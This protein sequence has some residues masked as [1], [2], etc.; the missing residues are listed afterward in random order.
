MAQKGNKAKKA[1]AWSY[2][3]GKKGKNRVRAYEDARDGALMLEWYEPLFDNSG[4]VID[5]RTGRQKVRRERISLT[6]NGVTTRVEAVAKAEQFA[7]KVDELSA[8]KAKPEPAHAASG[9]G[10]PEVVTLGYLLD[11]YFEEVVPNKRA[12]TRKQNDTDQR[13]FLAYFGRDAVVERIGPK[14]RPV[15]EMGRVR[16]ND[17]VRAR[18][19]GTIP[20]FAKAKGQTIRN[21]VRF[22][23]AVFKWAKLERDDGT[24]L[25]IRNPWEGFPDPPCDTPVRQEMTPELHRKLAEN[26]KNWRMAV[27]MEICRE[28][29]RRRNSVRLLAMEDIDL[30]RGAVRWQGEFDKVGKTRVTPLTRKAVDAILRAL[31]HRRAEGMDHSPWL[32]PAEANP[33]QPVPLTRL[34]NWMR[35]TKK[36]QGL[37]LP[38]LGYHGEKRAGIRDPKFR[39]LDP[40]VQEE[41]AGTT[42]E[43]MRRVYDYVD[44]PTL[45]N[46]VALLENDGDQPTSGVPQIGTRRGLKK[47]A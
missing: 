12:G 18:Q 38:R 32:I 42:W 26:A 17:F 4:P 16:Y 41:L 8:F 28:T 24:A 22:L 9:N 45:R 44:L 14:G 1:K 7:A 30:S 39:R 10:V 3:A 5:P 27:V 20:G 33:A 15:T 19:E 13:M 23:R 2:R 34:D 35:A 29:R 31:E 47:A 37:D 25:L 46:A 43:T 6:A 21:D 36:A 11:L 40:A